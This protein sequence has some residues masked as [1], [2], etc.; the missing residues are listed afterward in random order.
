M[1]FLLV[2]GR[3]P[4][5]SSLCAM[6]GKSIGNSYLRE[7]GTQL[8]YCDLNCHADHCKKVMSLPDRTRAALA[9]LAPG[10]PNKPAKADAMLTT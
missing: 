6:C 8:Y 5:R 9:A 3:T 1:N 7:M 4:C 10:R 2:N